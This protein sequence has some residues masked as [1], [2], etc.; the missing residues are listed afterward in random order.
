MIKKTKLNIS[1]G[2]N[3]NLRISN[4]LLSRTMWNDNTTKDLVLDDKTKETSKAG[5]PLDIPTN[6][7]GINNEKGNITFE[8]NR[9]TSNDFPK[10]SF[11]MTIVGSRR[12]GKSTITESLLNHELKNR[13]DYV[14]LYSPTLSGFDSIP[15]NYKFRDLETLPRLIEKQQDKVKN[16][17]LVS[18]LI[19]NNR[20][21]TIGEGRSRLEKKYQKSKICCVIDDM[22]G[23]KSLRHNDILN[24]IATNGRHICSPDKSNNTEMCFIILTQSITLL[25]KTIRQNADLILSSRLTSKIDRKLLIEENMVLDST[26]AG[27]QDS[28]KR[29][30]DITLS[31]DYSFIAILN[32]ISNKNNYD[33][34][35]RSYTSNAENFTDLKIFGNKDDWKTDLPFYD[36]K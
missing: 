8:K 1:N 16:N 25:D 35:I 12:T 28:F 5:R 31:K 7:A 15:N 13:F 21:G 23:S 24:K 17:I 14:F 18:K 2:N 22:A 3:N 6:Q 20:N 36:F 26:R 29:Y 19:N 32:W 27:L 10:S 4:P 11:L 30:D 9:L 34:Y 33:K